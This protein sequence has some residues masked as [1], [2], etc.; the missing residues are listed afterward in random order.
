[1]E[2]HIKMDPTEGSRHLIQIICFQGR[3]HP[4]TLVNMVMMSESFGFRRKQVINGVRF[5]K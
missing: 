4:E 1:M 3:D 5:V 2:D